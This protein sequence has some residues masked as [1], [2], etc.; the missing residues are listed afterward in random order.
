MSR[1][2]R[3]RRSELATPASNEHMFA[4]AAAAGADLV[5]LDLEDACAPAEREAARPKAAR[6]LR[7]LDWGATTRAIR[8]NGVDTRWAHGDVI[9]V[10][11]AARE[12]LDVIIV[13]KVRAARDVWWVDVLLTQLEETLGLGKRIGLEVLIEEVEG[14]Q[15]VDAIARSSD[16][17]EALIFGAGDFSAS[18]GARVDTNF[19][20]RADYPGDLWHYARSRIV[21]AARAA[22]IEAVDAPYPNYRDPDGYRTACERAGAMGFAGKWAIHPSQVEPA[23]DVFAPTPEEIAHA[24]RTVA[25]YRDAEAAGRGATG[26]DGM[27]VDAAHLRHAETVRTKAALLGRDGGEVR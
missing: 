8:M 5:F 11:T 2:V 24:R 4:K 22:G 20:P 1:P 3:A 12:A 23:N 14:L 19:D 21:V 27:L 26:L 18:Q 7:E 25:A 15:E 16:R 13:P 9:E 6:A 17:L 10:V